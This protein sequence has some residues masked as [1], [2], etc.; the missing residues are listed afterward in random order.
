MI[1]RNDS[2]LGLFNGDIG[3]ALPG[4]GGELRVHFQL[5]DGSI[6]SVQPSRLP[7]HETAYAMTVHKSQGSE[8][9]HTAL[10]LPNHFLPVLT[11][12]LV[13]TAITRARQR[14]SL[15]AV[16]KVLVALSAPPRSAAAG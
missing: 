2:A 13:Y 9:D 3:I 11:R 8:F 15:Y 6:K 5:P 16:D 4:E 7:A 12:E 1:G 14:L 10:V